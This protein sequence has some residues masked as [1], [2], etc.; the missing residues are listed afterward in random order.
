M[1]FDACINEKDALELHKGG[2]N[3]S[4]IWQKIE[5]KIYKYPPHF[6]CFYNFVTLEFL[7]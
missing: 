6:D 2:L 5:V 7:A 1:P 3:S 4:E